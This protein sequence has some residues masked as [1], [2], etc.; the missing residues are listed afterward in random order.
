LRNENGMLRP[1]RRSVILTPKSTAYCHMDLSEKAKLVVVVDTEEEF[2]WSCAFSRDY[3]SISS[4]RWI[5]RAQD[6]FDE[7]HIMPVY[8][9]DYPVASQA[10]GYRPLQEIY[11]SGR[12]LIGAHLHPWV[13]PPFKE[14]VNR[15]N[16]FPG[17]LPRALEAAKLQVL[18]DRIGELFGAH[19]TIYKAG[20]YGIGPHTAE[21]LEEQGYEVDLSVCPCMDYSAEG[22]P[23]FTHNSAWPFWFG[24]GRRLL[25][26]P[27]TVGFAGLL[28]HWGTP[29]HSI[30]SRPA[31]QKFHTVGALA[32][33]G[34]VDKIWLSPEGYTSAEHVK[35]VRA[36]YRDDLRVFSFAFHSPSVEPGNTPYV[37]SQRD[38][39]EFLTRCR[40]F[41]DFFMGELGGQP[42]T[43]LELKQQ[44]TACFGALRLEG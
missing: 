13:N 7:Y 42:T 17:N 30:A 22:G 10:D 20:R 9:I 18:S 29:L 27:L 32:R 4:M 14:P 36:L 26:L 5:S 8:V 44:L 40:K 38:L 43:P 25:G 37:R 41:F 12:C 28:R 2:D 3:I 33:L 34:L 16:S 19:P 35:L 15:Y 31:M 39:E 21:I 24:K 1:A 6:I 23:D 11:A